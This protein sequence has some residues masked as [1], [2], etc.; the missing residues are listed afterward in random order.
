[1]K[2]RNSLSSIIPVILLLCLT[3]ALYVFREPA[4]LQISKLLTTITPTFTITILPSPS[5][6]ITP[7]PTVTTT[8]TDTATATITPTSTN[9][10][11][12]TPA[13]T[14]T[15]NP[16]R[17]A[18]N[19]D[20]LESL[21][22]VTEINF[23]AIGTILRDQVAIS[24]NSAWLAIPT[25]D[26]IAVWRTY[27][28]QRIYTLPLD[29]SQ[30]TCIPKSIVFSPENTHI[31][32][33]CQYEG[34]SDKG[35]TGIWQLS[36]G[37]LI[38]IVNVKA[39]S[40]TFTPNATTLIYTD[41]ECVTIL[42]LKDGGKRTLY[43]QESVPIFSNVVVSPD[44]VYLSAGGE[45]VFRVWNIVDGTVAFEMDFELQHSLHDYTLTFSGNSQMVL[46]NG[47]VWDIKRKTVVTGTYLT[48]GKHYPVIWLPTE[49]EIIAYLQDNGHIGFME[50]YYGYTHQ[51]LSEPWYPSQCYLC[52]FSQNGEHYLSGE[53][54]Y[55]K[56]LYYISIIRVNS[57][58]E[59]YRLNDSLL[60]VGFF[61]SPDSS[62]LGAIERSSADT[63]T[64][65]V[66]KI[67][68]PVQ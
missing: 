67:Y 46:Y 63:W 58:Q 47:K 2:T 34:T 29:N 28:W 64:H 10:P 27:D 37:F 33:S 68:E 60:L 1:M 44:G 13:P 50:T 61:F 42:N 3:A 36:D 62:F 39:H 12:N 65:F 53:Y 55:Q 57:G 66:L 23:Q 48:Y 30:G 20:N 26:G 59:V 49:G 9:T 35:W 22:P 43:L 54:D 5:P 18:I 7:S 38:Y 41:R 4:R 16:P 8:P 25:D 56:K 15:T 40:L 24:N 6:T 14:A 32:A 17:A 21:S 52:P 51:Q 31:A 45:A 19:R 11:T